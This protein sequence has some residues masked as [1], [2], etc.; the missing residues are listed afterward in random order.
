MSSE[1]PTIVTFWYGPLSWLERLC[2]SSFVRHGHKV[3]LYTYEPVPN[4]PAGVTMRDASEILPRER[5]FFYKGRRTPGV[6]SDLFR[7]ELIRQKRGVWTDADVYCVKPF[8]NLPDYVFAYERPPKKDGSG[9]SVNGA[10][11]NMPPDSDL[12]KDL[13]DVFADHPHQL[14]EPHLSP[15]RRWEVAAKRLTGIKVPPE[16]MQYGSTG[17]AAITYHLRRRNMMHLV[18]PAEVFYPVPYN[19]IPSLMRKGSSIDRV[20]TAA[21]L[22]VHIWR[23]QITWR[24]RIGMPKP[25]QGSAL[26]ELCERDNIA[27]A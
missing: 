21:T 14:I 10:V 27:I 8:R 5:L 3:E 15:Y 18:Q 22:G 1:L 7:L 23:S 24:G 17:P 2:L 12:L 9:G 20:V 26:A 16:Y 25:A 6:F 13:M 11:I 4:L 19:H